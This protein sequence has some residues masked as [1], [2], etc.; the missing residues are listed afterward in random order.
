[1]ETLE[2]LNSNYCKVKPYFRSCQL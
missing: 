1:M 2:A